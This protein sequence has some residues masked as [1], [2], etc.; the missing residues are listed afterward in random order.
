[1]LVS[2]VKMVGI[3]LIILVVM[4]IFNK[5]V[6]KLLNSKHDSP[7]IIEFNLESQPGEVEI[8][9]NLIS[10]EDGYVK[11]EASL[12]FTLTINDIEILLGD[13]TNDGAIDVL[14]VVLV[15]NIIMEYTTPDSSQIWSAD[16][17]NDGQINIQDIVLLVNIILG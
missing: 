2:V 7:I 14:D 10:N 9:V 13:V 5:Y 15:V 11:Y 8:L 4:V 1:M 17:N 3:L 16:I 6:S 12:P